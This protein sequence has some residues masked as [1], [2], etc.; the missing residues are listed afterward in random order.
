MVIRIA[1]WLCF[2]ECLAGLILQLSAAV[3]SGS[4]Q[5][6]DATIARR[7]HIFKVLGHRVRLN[8]EL[9]GG[10]GEI[11]G[12]SVY[13]AINGFELHEGDIVFDLGANYG[14]FTT[15]AGCVGSKAVAV[16]A[17]RHFLRQIGFAVWLVGNDQNVVGCI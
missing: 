16:D 3:R 2:Y 10:A 14:V 1:G 6:A 13:F 7:P 8:G 12:R 11:Y 4:L 5:P 17:Q 9:F 15:L